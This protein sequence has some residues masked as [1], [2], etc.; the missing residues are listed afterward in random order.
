MKEEK[1]PKLE[2][3]YEIKMYHLLI[4]FVVSIFVAIGIGTLLGNSVGYPA[5]YT[6][7]ISSISV[8]TPNYCHAE[9]MSNNIKIVCNELE[10]I[11]LAD[12]CNTLS[13]PLEHKLKI[14]ITG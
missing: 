7:G 3:N 13:T 1:D 6:E 5:G 4:L 11:T 14:L 8:S 9:G 10:N 12:M 2:I